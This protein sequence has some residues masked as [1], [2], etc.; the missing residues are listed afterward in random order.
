VEVGLTLTPRTLRESMLLCIDP[1]RNRA[2]IWLISV[3]QAVF[4]RIWVASP[5]STFREIRLIGEA[6]SFPVLF[7]LESWML[8]TALVFAN[9]YLYFCPSLRSP[10]L[11]SMRKASLRP[12][13][14]RIP[15]ASSVDA[16]MLSITTSPGSGLTSSMSR[17][18][19][20]LSCSWVLM[21][22]RNVVLPLPESPV[23]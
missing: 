18:T 5:R 15:I 6:S 19:R 10:Y 13:L 21:R 12:T 16:P 1:P 20:P 3:I 14:L 11:R 8:P 17:T 22:R 7:K 4:K 23:M 9:L 2:V